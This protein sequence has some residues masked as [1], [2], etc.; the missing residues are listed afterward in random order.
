MKREGIC[1]LNGQVC[2][3]GWRIVEQWHLVFRLGFAHAVA[4][5]GTEEE[6]SH[7]GYLQREDMVEDCNFVSRDHTYLGAWTRT[8]SYT[9]PQSPG[10]RYL[11]PHPYI[12][13]SP[14]LR[15][16]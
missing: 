12:S 1:G 10:I 15:L 11:I 5:Q 14:L 16:A 13:I 6:D 3:L 9:I 7:G 4:S 2:C 8:A